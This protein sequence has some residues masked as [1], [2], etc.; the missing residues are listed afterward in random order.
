MTKVVNALCIASLMLAAWGCALWT[1]GTWWVAPPRVQRWWVA[2][3]GS[4]AYAVLCVWCFRDVLRNLPTVVAIDG[5]AGSHEQTDAGKS[6]GQPARPIAPVLVVYASETGF[7]EELAQQTVDL[8]QTLNRSVELLPLE[9]VTEVKLQQTSQAFFLA[10][11]A[12]EGEPPGHACEFHDTM[13]QSVWS[14][15]GLR[16]AVLALGDSSYDEYCAFGRSVD[17]WLQRCGAVTSSD[18]IEVDDAD[19]IALANWQASVEATVHG[20]LVAS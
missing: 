6:I 8:L 16:Y 20:E 12:G 13:M 5:V 17:A 2:T 14:L 9:E 15:S 3:G 7:A 10:S 19:P 1:D 18:R 4:V 11:T